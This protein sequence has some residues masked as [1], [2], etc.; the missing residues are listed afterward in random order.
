[1]NIFLIQNTIDTKSKDSIQL[2]NKK[3]EKALKSSYILTKSTDK[4]LTLKKIHNYKSNGHELIYKNLHSDNNINIKWTNNNS[5]AITINITKRAI[6]FMLL[7]SIPLLII[8]G[9]SIG[10]VLFTITLCSIIY[11]VIRASGIGAVERIRKIIIKE[12]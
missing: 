10:W 5:L 11:F 12:L 2:I 4:S 9:I 8:Q 1:M 6:F 7:T 3:I